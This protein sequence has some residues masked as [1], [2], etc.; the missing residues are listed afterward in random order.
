VTPGTTLVL[1]GL[2]LGALVVTGP[3]TPQP[4]LRARADALRTL[5]ITA[6]RNSASAAQL[7]RDFRARWSAA[8]D[9]A[10]RQEDH[11]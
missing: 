8:E 5:T 9:A 2:G 4:S 7:A 11:G 10:R 1:L 3:S 6:Q